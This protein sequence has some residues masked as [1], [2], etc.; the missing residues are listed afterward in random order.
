MASASAELEALDDAVEDATASAELEALDHAVEDAARG[1]AG[2]GDPAAARGEE[3]KDPATDDEGSA[4]LCSYSAR[5][6]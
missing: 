6:R 5:S 3:G 1:E 4:Q 2:G